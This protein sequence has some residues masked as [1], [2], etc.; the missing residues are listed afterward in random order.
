MAVA[1]HLAHQ[2]QHHD[3]RAFVGQFGN[4][5]GDVHSVSENALGGEIVPEFRFLHQ[6]LEVQ[7]EQ[8]GREEPADEVSAGPGLDHEGQGGDDENLAGG[9]DG[10]QSS[11]DF[12][13]VA[14]E[15]QEERGIEVGVADEVVAFL[16]VLEQGLEVEEGQ[17][18][19]E[20]EEEHGVEDAQV[21]RAD[22]AEEEAEPG[23]H[24]HEFQQHAAHHS[25]H[26]AS[27]HEQEDLPHRQPE[28]VEED[29]GQDDDGAVVHHAG[30]EEEP[31][32]GAFPVFQEVLEP[33]DEDD[34]GQGLTN[35]V[36][37]ADDEEAGVVGAEAQQ[38]IEGELLQ[39]LHQKA[40]GEGRDGQEVEVDVV[41]DALQEDGEEVEAVFGIAFLFVVPLPEG[42]GLVVEEGDV[43]DGVGAALAPETDEEDHADRDGRQDEVALADPAEVDEKQY[44]QQEEDERIDVHGYLLCLG[45]GEAAHERGVEPGTAQQ[46]APQT[47]F[48]VEVGAADA[49]GTETAQTA[50]LFLFQGEGD[51]AEE[52]PVDAEEL[53]GVDPLAGCLVVGAVGGVAGAFNLDNLLP[54][55][56]GFQHLLVAAGGGDAAFPVEVVVDTHIAEGHAADVFV[57][58][59]GELVV[60]VDDAF[61]EAHRMAGEELPAHEEEPGAD[62]HGVVADVGLARDDLAHRLP[63]G[64]E[65]CRALVGPDVAVVEGQ[66]VEVEGVGLVE[67]VFQ[68]PAL[69]VVVRVD[70]PDVFAAGMRDAEV[71]GRAQA[72]VGLVHEDQVGELPA[73]LFDQGDGAVL[74]TVVHHDDFIVLAGDVLLFQGTDA[75]F[76]VAFHVVDGY[77]EG[78]TDHSFLI[79]L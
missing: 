38:R 50:V 42:V 8:Q 78:E 24:E 73:E 45:G 44:R 17:A 59:E 36:H 21:L 79:F 10:G 29:E 28:L 62:A 7:E 68:H 72:A 32:E 33:V 31:Q 12:S 16:P 61:G 11:A 14:G 35:L 1:E 39:A 4:D 48:E 52:E 55:A 37:V 51:A 3:D 77:D 74:R 70:E 58:V 9:E 23:L 40:D 65:A 22:V 71:A 5:I 56:D 69:D 46:T 75:P 67:Q 25:G 30:K 2:L 64:V 57:E 53:V 15:K 60:L 18:E 13:H 6:L 54:A 66:Q 34:H 20:L 43:V 41:P 27:G 76:H 19:E 63:G 26:E 49:E 47:A